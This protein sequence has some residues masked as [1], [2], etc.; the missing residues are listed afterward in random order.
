MKL[1]R[2]IT[3]RRVKWVG[4]VLCV[5]VLGVGVGV[6]SAWYEVEW[7]PVN[8][9]DL[10]VQIRIRAGGLAIAVFEPD[11]PQKGGVGPL[12]ALRFGR[13]DNPSIDLMPIWLWRATLISTNSGTFTVPDASLPLW[14][15]L[16]L[17][18]VPTGY[19]WY[20]ERRPKCWQC[21]KCRYDL[22]GL[23]GGGEGGGDAFF[24]ECGEV[25]TPSGTR[26][27]G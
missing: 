9:P 16:L 2:L 25:I 12:D 10:S 14:I 20:I 6:A 19:L 23:E 27:R 24:P 8:K 11:A 15:P 13:L 26:G 1:P 3:R 5:L 17:I 4:T 21:V 18:A 7:W 22:R